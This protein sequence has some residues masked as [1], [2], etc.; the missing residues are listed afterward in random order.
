MTQTNLEIAGSAR[1]FSSLLGKERMKVWLVQNKATK[2]YLV[3]DHP[4]E[5]KGFV[6]L[7]GPVLEVPDGYEVLDILDVLP[8]ECLLPTEKPQNKES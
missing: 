3:I 8:P 2:K 1:F 4:A 7:P 5:Q 6:P